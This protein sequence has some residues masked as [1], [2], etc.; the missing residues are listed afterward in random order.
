MK[1]FSPRVAHLFPARTLARLL[2]PSYAIAMRVDED[3]AHERLAQALR[4]AALVSDLQRG[5]ARAIEERRGPRTTEDKLLDAISAGLE[6]HGGNVRAAPSS[7]AVAGVMV[8]VN[9]EIGLAPEPMRATLAEG[10]GAAVLEE[11]LLAVGRQL[12]KDLLR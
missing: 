7:P 12:V 9:L 3:E 8:R 10:R 6:K 1:Q 2:T 4:S 5:I 11:G